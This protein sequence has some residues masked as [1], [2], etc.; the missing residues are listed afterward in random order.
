MLPVTRDGH[1]AEQA[2]TYIYNWPV[3]RLPRI[4]S[5]RFLEQ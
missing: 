4:E 3:A 2:W 1:A 5:G